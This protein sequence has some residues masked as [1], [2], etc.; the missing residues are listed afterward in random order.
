MTPELYRERLKKVF[1][2]KVCKIRVKIETIIIY[3][4]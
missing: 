3:P 1:E 2:R 4:R